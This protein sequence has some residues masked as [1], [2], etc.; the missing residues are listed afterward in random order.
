MSS[1]TEVEGVGV[2]TPLEIVIGA[3]NK[4]IDELETEIIPGSHENEVDGYQ[5]EVDKVRA[6]VEELERDTSINVYFTG[7]E[8]GPNLFG[9]VYDDEDGVLEAAHENELH[10]WRVPVQPLLAK[11]VRLDGDHDD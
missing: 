7:D 6:A 8:D 2:P 3:A 10:G 1:K 4:W 9:V 5:A 11:A